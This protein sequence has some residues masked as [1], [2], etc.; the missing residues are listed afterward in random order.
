MT[1]IRIVWAQES[2]YEKTSTSQINRQYGT[3]EKRVVGRADDEYILVVK[4]PLAASM[5]AI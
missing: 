1:K 3:A 5:D 4:G 2:S